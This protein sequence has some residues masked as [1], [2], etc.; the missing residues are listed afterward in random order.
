MNTVGL[1]MLHVFVIRYLCGEAFTEADVRLF[2]TLVRHD[3]VYHG[4]FKCN[5][6]VRTAAA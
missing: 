2:V 4:H 6:K 3:E 1:D 5:K